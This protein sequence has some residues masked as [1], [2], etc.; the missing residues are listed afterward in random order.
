MIINIAYKADEIKKP[1]Y[2]GDVDDQ[3]YKLSNRY[4]GNKQSSGIMLFAPF[5]RDIQISVPNESVVNFTRAVKR[6]LTKHKIGHDVSS[7]R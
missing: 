3:L 6:Y 1:M 4:N 5:W 7:Y 2:L